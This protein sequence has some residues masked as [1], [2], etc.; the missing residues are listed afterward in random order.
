MRY[1]FVAMIVI[2]AIAGAISLVRGKEDRNQ[3]QNAEQPKSQN[4]EDKKARP[5]QK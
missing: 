4:P 2:L 5:G 1:S 3:G